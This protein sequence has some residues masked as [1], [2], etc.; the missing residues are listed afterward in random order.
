MRT[1]HILSWFV[2]A[3]LFPAVF[4]IAQEPSVVMAQDEPK[5]TPFT[6]ELWVYSYA[7]SPTGAIVQKEVTAVSRTGSRAQVVTMSLDDSL[8]SASYVLRTIERM[9]RFFAR[10]IDELRLVSSSYLANRDRITRSAVLAA[11]GCIDPTHNSINL[12]HERVG[13]FDTVVLQTNA[14]SSLRV[15]RWFSPTLGCFVL[16]QKNERIQADGSYRLI[17]EY[18]LQNLQTGEPDATLFAVP[19]SYAEVRP[20]EQGR[21]LLDHLGR[22][23]PASILEQWAQE[24]REYDNRRASK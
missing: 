1:Q 24:D 17:T 20:S 22:N 5:F 23:P 2:S 13:D 9:D 11:Q 16:R 7:K 3:T 21:K 18:K 19:S 6:A 8:D 15:T 4:F 14:A 12:G 10:V